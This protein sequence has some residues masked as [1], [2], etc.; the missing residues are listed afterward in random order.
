MIQEIYYL[1]NLK[2]AENSPAVRE[3]LNQFTSMLPDQF[4]QPYF[5]PS[6]VGNL[7]SVLRANCT[8]KDCSVRAVVHIERESG[9]LKIK[10]KKPIFDRQ[11]KSCDKC[12]ELF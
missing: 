10:E 9:I 5:V 4:G 11:K 2:V 1:L 8:N 7:A 6:P 3:L 12:K